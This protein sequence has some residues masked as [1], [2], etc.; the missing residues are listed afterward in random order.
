VTRGGVVG[1]GGGGGGKGGE[2]W[3]LS[4][5]SGFTESGK[6]AVEEKDVQGNGSSL[7]VKF[8]GK[9]KSFGEELLV[10]E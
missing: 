9:G 3:G 7:Q 4:V 8:R 5:A 6:G 1:E 10:G 2:V